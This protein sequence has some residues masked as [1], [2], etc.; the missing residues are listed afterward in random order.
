MPLLQPSF[1]GRLRLFFA[2]IVV[3]PMIAVAIVLF[4]LLDANDTAKVN[5]RLAQ[6]QVARDRTF[7][8]QRDE[9]HQAAPMAEPDVRLATAIR[10]DKPAEVERQL[11][12][13]ASET[14][15][16]RIELEV[17][18]QAHVRDRAQGRGARRTCPIW[19]T[20]AGGRSGT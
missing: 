5:S 4:Q 16:E 12:Q 19:R 10:D 3:V 14:G 9:A 20:P 13:I 1:R 6:A 11:A 17:D 7:N 2:V 15:A 18:G 8:E